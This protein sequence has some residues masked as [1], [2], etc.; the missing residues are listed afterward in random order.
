MTLQTNKPNN[1]Y[2]IIA[3][4]LLIIVLMLL[5]SCN[6][7]KLHK[8]KES[9]KTIASHE[10]TVDS[11][12]GHG[13]TLVAWVKQDSARLWQQIES[14]NDGMVINF[15][16]SY[17]APGE[18]EITI[19]R[20]DGK[21]TINPGNRKVKSVQANL[22]TET[23]KFDSTGTSTTSAKKINTFD[24]ASLKKSEAGHTETETVKSEKDKKSKRFPTVAV[25]IFVVIASVAFLLYKKF[26]KINIQG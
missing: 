3:L 2:S 20:Q 8:T 5:F 6:S 17:Y 18:T 7:T 1:I 14:I 11:V 25:T 26:N 19:E 23:K 16:S 22:K 9:T 21:I 24:S 13:A 15:D 12:G 4:Y 10:L